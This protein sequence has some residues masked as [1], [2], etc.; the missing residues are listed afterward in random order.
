MAVGAVAVTLL[1]GAAACSSRAKSVGHADSNQPTP[2]SSQLNVT[3]PATDL[4]T[5]AGALN[6][7]LIAAPAGAKVHAIKPGTRGTGQI[8]EDA[9]PDQGLAGEAVE[10]FTTAA[11]HDI[12]IDISQFDT[13]LD[14]GETFAAEVVTDRQMNSFPLPGV[15]GAGVS[16]TFVDDNAPDYQVDAFAHDGDVV[17]EVMDFVKMASADNPTATLANE[18]LAEQYKKLVG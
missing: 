7:Y 10:W 17:I 2:T 18:I 1:L 8:A 13:A 3:V 16:G 5:H 14:A 11:G 4:Q 6:S 9:G 12:K 15:T